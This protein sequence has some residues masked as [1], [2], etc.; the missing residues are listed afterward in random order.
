SEIG[1]MEE[2]GVP[3]VWNMLHNFGGRMGLDGELETI[4]NKITK[5]KNN[6]DHMVGIGITPEAINNSPIVYDLLSDMIWTQDPVNYRNWTEEYI[7]YKY[8]KSSENLEEAWEILI[9]TAYKQK[10]S[11]YQGASESV[12]NAKPAL[13]INSA[14]TWGHSDI[15]YDKKAFEK[16]I[17]LFISEY[18]TFKDNPAFIY[19]F[20]DVTKQLLA[21][22]AQD[23]HKQI[24]NAYDAKN[25]EEFEAVSDTFLSLI[26]LQDDVLSTSDSFLLG[27]WIDDSR[28]MLDTMDDWTK[29]L[30]EFNAR[31]LITTWGAKKN[32]NGGGLDDYSNRQWS[33]LTRDYYL[34]RWEKWVDTHVYALKNDSSPKSFDWFDNGWNWVNKKSDQEVFPT[35]STDLNLA[36]LAQE[37]YEI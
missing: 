6:T 25:V 3:W 29:D 34:P 19:D 2:H 23:Y 20:V 5:D 8:G 13:K 22:A 31:A 4:A 12:I 11:Y 1:P 17:P 14:S 37:A 36:E 16:V 33:G 10:D 28:N 15:M 27:T 7:E 18:E 9:D 35:T 26:E 21:N 30:F 24:A 32:A